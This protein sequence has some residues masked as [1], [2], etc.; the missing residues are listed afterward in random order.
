[1]TVPRYRLSFTTGALLVKEAGVV[2][3]LYL[4]MRD[5]SKVR[6]LVDDENRLQSRVVASGRRLARETVQRLAGRCLDDGA[7]HLLVVTP[8]PQAVQPEPHLFVSIA[9]SAG[10]DEA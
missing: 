3:P 2:A 10:H 5:W 6:K 9:A 8:G 7:L 4:D 1:M